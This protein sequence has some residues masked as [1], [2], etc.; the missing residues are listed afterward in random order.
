MRAEPAGASVPSQVRCKLQGNKGVGSPHV[1]PRFGGTRE[2]PVATAARSD[3][4]APPH[5]DGLKAPRSSSGCRPSRGGYPRPT[6]TARKAARFRSNTSIYGPSSCVAS[7][8]NAKRACRVPTIRALDAVT[9]GVRERASRG[10][11]T[12]GSVKSG[13]RPLDSSIPDRRAAHSRFRRR[14]R[15]RS[16]RKMRVAPREQRHE[17][18]VELRVARSWSSLL[19]APQKVSSNP[20]AARWERDARRSQPSIQNPSPASRRFLGLQALA[21][22]HGGCTSSACEGAPR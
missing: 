11:S 18:R 22:D 20:S 8:G 15:V 9:R 2:R 17:V 3:P 1:I 7:R 19:A 10:S 21:T 16:F 13:S 6:R 12:Q 14:F 5:P 4:H